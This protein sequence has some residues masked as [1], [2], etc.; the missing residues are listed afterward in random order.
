M[1]LNVGDDTSL[2]QTEMISCKSMGN[3]EIQDF[4]VRYE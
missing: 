2:L 3:V 4:F 1:L